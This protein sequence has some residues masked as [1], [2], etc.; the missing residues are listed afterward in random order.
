VYRFLAFL[1][2]E[3]LL[4]PSWCYFASLILRENETERDLKGSH[5]TKLSDFLGSITLL[6]SLLSCGLVESSLCSYAQQGASVFCLD[7]CPGRDMMC[8]VSTDGTLGLWS[9]LGARVSFGQLNNGLNAVSCSF[10][11]DGALLASSSEDGAVR[12]WNVERRLSLALLRRHTAAVW[13]VAMSACGGLLTGSSD[14]SV[15]LWDLDH[16]APRAT[17]AVPQPVWGVSMFPDASVATVALQGGAALLWDVRAPTAAASLALGGGGG[18]LPCTCAVSADGLCVALAGSSLAVWDVRCLTRPL[19]A[20]PLG[21][22]A[23]SCAFHPS[24]RLLALA[25]QCGRAFAFDVAAARTGA[26]VAPISAVLLS[27]ARPQRLPSPAR[28]VC[29]GRDG[30]WLAAGLLDGGVRRLSV[31]GTEGT[32]ETEIGDRDAGFVP[33]YAEFGRQQRR[34]QPRIM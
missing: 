11:P 23:W 16:L 34:L 2:F 5:E 26:V 22:H 10:S 13:S 31:M 15:L 18:G 28:S 8:A 25:S 21:A 24:G 19:L 33:W 3:H 32:A 17:L 29:F 12:L 4:K 9:T 1:S 20:A 6:M 14:R 27:P 7:E 30:T